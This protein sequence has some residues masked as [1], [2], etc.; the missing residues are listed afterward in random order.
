MLIVCTPETQVMFKSKGHFVMLTKI[1]LILIR[2]NPG[3]I[4]RMLA[5]MLMTMMTKMTLVVMIIIKNTD[6][7]IIGLSV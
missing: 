3:H 4:S 1:S 7:S 5:L 6:K 2:V